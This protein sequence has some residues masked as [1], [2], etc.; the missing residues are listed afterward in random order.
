MHKRGFQ[1]YSYIYLNQKALAAILVQGA[2]SRCTLHWFLCVV[3][4]QDNGTS[5]NY[6]PWV[7]GIAKEWGRSSEQKES[8]LLRNKKE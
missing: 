5:C 8:V 2:L 6:T 1:T 7:T 3:R 4:V